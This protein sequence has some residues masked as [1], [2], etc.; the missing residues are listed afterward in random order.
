MADPIFEVP[1]SPEYNTEIRKLQTTDPAHADNTFNP[2]FE[3]LIGNIHHVKLAEDVL[4]E[5]VEEVE[6]MAE[7]A[8]DPSNITLEDGRTLDEA[9]QDL[10]QAIGEAARAPQAYKAIVPA[11]GW[12]EG[13]A[14]E[15][16]SYWYECNITDSQIEASDV[17]LVFPADEAAE[18]IIKACFRTFVDTYAGGLRLYAN[19]QPGQD[20]T[21]FYTISKQEG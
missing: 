8:G 15:D 2:L 19:A 4:E 7:E 11:S 17:V 13:A 18:E 16:N 20:V 14:A 12:T 3:T 6:K 5:K 10:E 21:I 1:D 9:L